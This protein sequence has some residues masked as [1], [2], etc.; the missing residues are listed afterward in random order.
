MRLHRVADLHELA[1][2]G[3]VAAYRGKMVPIVEVTDVADPF[4]P[5]AVS[6]L[7]ALLC[8]S[9]GRMW[10]SWVVLS[11]LVYNDEVN[12]RAD[13]DGWC[14]SVGADFECTVFT[15]P[16]A[17]APVWAPRGPRRAVATPGGI[18]PK[19]PRSAR[20]HAT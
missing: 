16:W 5:G 15:A 20:R 3:E 6:E 14:Y 17:A 13:H 11:L 1:E 2:L 10:C 18:R 12:V 19:P 4:Q 8:R 7:A 9:L